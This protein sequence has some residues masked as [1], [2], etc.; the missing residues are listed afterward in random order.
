MARTPQRPSSADGREPPRPRRRLAP[1]ALSLLAMAM[2]RPSAAETEVPKWVET[3]KDLHPQASV[4]ATTDSNLLRNPDG[5]GDRSDRYLTLQA[6][7]DTEFKFSR[8]RLLLDASVYR[9]DYERFS[10]FNH[11]GGDAKVLW[12]WVL[13]RLW[14]GEFGYSYDHKQRDF[15]NE[16]LPSNDMLSRHRLQASANRWLTTRWRLGARID[17]ADVSFSDSEE[18]DKTI[19]GYGANLDYVSKAGNTLSL[20][21]TYASADFKNR[22]DRDYDDLTLGPSVDWK[23]SGKTRLSASAGYKAR[24]HDVADERDFDGFVGRVSA[25]W[26]PTG[27]SSLKATAW[28]DISNLDDEIAD[29]AVIEGISLEPRWQ[30]MPKTSLRG[31]ASYENRAFD[32]GQDDELGFETGDRRDRVRVLELGLDWEPRRYLELGLSFRDESRESN[33]ALRE[34]DSQSLWLTVSAGF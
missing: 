21:A 34:Y 2:C 20:R 12:K 5:L 17:W 29:Y 9:N 16:L 14:E 19:L 11:V 6:G 4:T 8:Q 28:R 23:L 18:L 31:L 26:K 1:L 10:E 27:K 25:T 33:R 30:F 7:F 13:G 15:A 22:D 32:G 24:R 3:L